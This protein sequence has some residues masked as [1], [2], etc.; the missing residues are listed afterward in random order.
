M[1]CGK[2]VIAGL[3]GGLTDIIIHGYNGYLIQINVTNL[4]TAIEELI[5]DSDKRQKMGR[6]A[7][8]VA[9]AFRQE[10]WAQ[11]WAGVI[12]EVFK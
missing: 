9:L 5:Q 4:E 10:I 7:R 12:E 8:E 6:H 3:A 2:P 11:R 1:S